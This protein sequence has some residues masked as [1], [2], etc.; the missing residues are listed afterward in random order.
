MSNAEATI[1]QP[2]TT[3][4]NAVLGLA[5]LFITYFAATYFF[6][7]IGVAL[8]KVAADLNGM[9]LYS[10]A[11]SVPAL[12]AAFATIV[13]GKLSD[14]Y[15][16]RLL[17][18]GSLALYLAGALLSAISLDFAF[19]I[20]ARSILSL[21]QGALST[22]C[23][24]TLGDLYSPVERSRWSGLLQISAGVAAIIGPTMVGM[25]TDKLSWRYFFGLTALLAAISGALVLVG[26]ASSA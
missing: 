7:G 3:K 12:A 1:Q 14:A 16:R 5:A 25:I 21:G 17:L 9:A 4:R 6:R 20:V 26:L 19:F 8:P 18:I 23:F 22:L 10:W 13:I 24:S 11:I 15:G 2:S